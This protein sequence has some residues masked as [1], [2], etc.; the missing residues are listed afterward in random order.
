ME[1]GRRRNLPQG[2]YDQVARDIEVRQTLDYALVPPRNDGRYVVGV[3]VR[4]ETTG[5]GIK[6]LTPGEGSTNLKA[7]AHPLVDFHLQSV[8]PR[9]SLENARLNLGGRS[10]RV[11]QKAGHNTRGAVLKASWEPNHHAVPFPFSTAAQLTSLIPPS[12]PTRL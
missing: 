1:R 12:P 6:R 4:R 11:D 9:L 2:V 5:G 10:L 7:M 3:V 8:V